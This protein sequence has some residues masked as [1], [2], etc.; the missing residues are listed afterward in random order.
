M[1]YF[2]CSEHQLAARNWF[3][4]SA[5]WRSKHA[6]IEPPPRES[7]ESEEVPEGYS[8]SAWQSPAKRRGSREP[9]AAEG[10]MP[11][12]EREYA[13]SELPSTPEDLPTEPPELF[14]TLLKL[15]SFPSDETKRMVRE[16]RL[17]PWMWSDAQEIATFLRGHKRGL[18]ND[19]IRTFLKQYGSRAKL[20][21]GE[22]GRFEFIGDER[23]ESSFEFGGRVGRRHDDPIDRFIRYQIARDDERE[24]KTARVEVEE[25]PLAKRLV[26]LEALLK[27][28]QDMMAQLQQERLDAEERRK[29]ELQEE[30]FHALEMKVAEGKKSDSDDGWFQRYIQERDK[31]AED[32]LKAVQ[33]RYDALIKDQNEKLAGAVKAVQEAQAD[34][35]TARASAIQEA[36]ESDERAKKKLLEGGYAPRAKS[37]DERVLDIAEKEVVPGLMTEARELRKTVEKALSGGTGI[38]QRQAQERKPV[39]GEEAARVAEA[40]GI[41]QE[42]KDKAGPS[43]S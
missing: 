17:S 25:G 43:G 9:E 13:E 32:Q 8:L 7:V 5:H 36:E 12:G 1:P 30:R 35:K 3:G 38:A 33:D 37:T 23:A 24:R 19:W 6:G 4:F 34:A 2:L 42:M 40:M 20:S 10:E 11:S 41:Q 31:R 27:Q 28:Q 21:R 26:T 29:E 22:E 15:K 16:F 18:S 39:T 14:E